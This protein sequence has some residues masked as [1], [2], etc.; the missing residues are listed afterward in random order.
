MANTT[1]V[2]EDLSTELRRIY[3]ELRRF[4]IAITN[5]IHTLKQLVLPAPAKRCDLPSHVDSSLCDSTHD[6]VG[7]CR[8]NVFCCPG[9]VL[10]RQL[11][12]TFC[13]ELRSLCSAVKRLEILLLQQLDSPLG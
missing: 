7:I 13:V 2:T 8:H 4:H 9:P 3:V 1:Q 12:D 5:Q 11:E 6:Q 10:A